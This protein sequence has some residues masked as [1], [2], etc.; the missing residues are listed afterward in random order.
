MI[1]NIIFDLGNV[2]LK[3]RWDIVLNR[4]T[5]DPETIQLLN[6]IIFDSEEWK[7]LDAGTIS[8]DQALGQMLSKLPVYL[9]ESCKAI[10]NEWRDG[11]IINE[12]IISFIQRVRNNGYKTYIL[13]NA[14]HEIPPFLEAN[15]LNRFFDGQ[16]I[17][18]EEKV[19]KPDEKIYNLLLDKYDLVAEESIFLDDK[20][21]NI[22]GANS[23]N[24]NGIVYDHTNHEQML[25]ELDK[26]DVNYR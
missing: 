6:E 4:H 21:E 2:V 20:L 9:H 15:D 5:Q 22:E 14:P 17:S 23:V 7:E 24:I 16:I 19:C 11:L 3:L 26:Y 13:S 1:K 12:K 25:S 18:A 8:K 10:M